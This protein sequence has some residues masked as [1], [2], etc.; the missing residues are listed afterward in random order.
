MIKNILL[1]KLGATGD[2]VRTTP[3]LRRLSAKVT[4]LT[5][6]KNTVLLTDLSPNLRCFRWEDRAQAFDFAYD[7]VIN[8]EDSIEVAEFAR[9]PA[10]GATVVGAYLDSNNDLKY[11]DDSSNWFN[12][13][14]IS[15]YGRKEADRLKLLN[16]RTYQDMIFEAVGLP[17]SGEEY[18]LPARAD[19]DLSG[20]V[21]VSGE[22]GPVWPM[23]N[24]A[25]YNELI[26]VLQVDGLTVNVLP[27]RASLLEHLADVCNHRCLVGGDSLPMHLALGSGTRCVSL[28]TC[29]SPWE[30]Y[31]YGIQTKVISPLLAEYDRR[32][33]TAISVSQVHQAVIA[34]LEAATKTKRSPAPVIS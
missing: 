10:K 22:A 29:T 34:Q 30:I 28:F 27:K 9:T 11:T 26:E 13:S 23:K 24:W 4:W 33:V 8:L 18:V 32:A 14:L 3:L 6:A 31:D 1:I 16:R 21:A 20:D 5:E 25:Y 12:L 17:F 15:S 19:T 2:V 7:T